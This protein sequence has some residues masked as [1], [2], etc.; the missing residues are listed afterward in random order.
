M[1]A[2]ATFLFAATD[3]MKG[4]QIII[5]VFYVPLNAARYDKK[6]CRGKRCQCRRRIVQAEP[7]AFVQFNKI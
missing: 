6:P 3:G 4:L 1:E 5:S 2:C 7:D